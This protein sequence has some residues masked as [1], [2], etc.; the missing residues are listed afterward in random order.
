MNAKSAKDYL[1][2]IEALI[3]GELQEK[4]ANE[5]WR[6]VDSIDFTVHRDW[7]RRRPK[8]RE[9]W[10]IKYNDGAISISAIPVQQKNEFEVVHV[11]EVKE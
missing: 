11:R 9:W 6:D 4:F 1:P 5:G 7:Y 2:A 8:V 10:L 3:D